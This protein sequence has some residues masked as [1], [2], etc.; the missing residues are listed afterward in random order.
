ME[1]YLFP[2]KGQHAFP[3]GGAPAEAQAKSAT[4]SDASG[5]SQLKGGVD[6]PGFP[7][8]QEPG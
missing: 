8:H 3:E 2:V 4:I 5:Q 6:L 7:G 1:M